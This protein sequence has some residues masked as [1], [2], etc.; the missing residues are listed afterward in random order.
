[1]GIEFIKMVGFYRVKIDGEYRGT[2]KKFEDWTV[3]GT[4]IRWQAQSKNGVYKG[5][6]L[7]RREAADLLAKSN[8][9]AA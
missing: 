4:S 1:M 6:A 2:V 5:S 8:L 3:R 9:N 7:T